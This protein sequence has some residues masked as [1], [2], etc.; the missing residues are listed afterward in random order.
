MR[1]NAINTRYASWYAKEDRLVERID[2]RLAAEPKKS[3]EKQIRVVV[4]KKDK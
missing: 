2:R 3:S 1:W 4:V